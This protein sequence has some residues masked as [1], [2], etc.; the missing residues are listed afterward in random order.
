MQSD[1]EIKKIVACLDN[2][3]VMLMPTDTVYGLAALPICARAVERIYEL[4]HRPDR[5]NLPIMVDSAKRLPALGLAIG[6]AAQCLLN[7]PLVPG[8]LT[9]PWDSS[10]SRFQVGL[11]G[12]TR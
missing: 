2:C 3:G 5:M 11:R 9:L 4:K 6:E 8:A 1:D 10:S 12:G 7:S